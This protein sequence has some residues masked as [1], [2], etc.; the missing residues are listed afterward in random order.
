MGPQQNWRRTAQY[1]VDN[2]KSGKLYDLCDCDD[3][4][5][6]RIF[7]FYIKNLSADTLALERIYVEQLPDIKV[8]SILV[9]GGGR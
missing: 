8:V 3:E 1:V 2:Y 5:V 9:L 6:D 7:N 4:E